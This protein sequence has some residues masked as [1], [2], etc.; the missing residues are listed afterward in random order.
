MEAGQQVWVPRNHLWVPGQVLD[1]DSDSTTVHTDDDSVEHVP[2]NIVLPRR[3]LDG[4]ESP[5]DLAML[6]HLDEPNI[7]RGYDSRIAWRE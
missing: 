6:A 2:S 3:N 7:L 1:M 4:E 5:A